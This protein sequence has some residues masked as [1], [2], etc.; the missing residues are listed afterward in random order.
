MCVF[1]F[2]DWFIIFQMFLNMWCTIQ[3]LIIVFRWLIRYKQGERIIEIG[4][5]FVVPFNIF[6]NVKFL[7]C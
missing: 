3:E 5:V 6:I 2:G 1:F 4:K 7:L